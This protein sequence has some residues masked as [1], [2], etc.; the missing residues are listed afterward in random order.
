MKASPNP[1]INTTKSEFFK[2]QEYIDRCA[3]VFEKHLGKDRAAKFPNECQ[4]IIID[5]YWNS[6]GQVPSLNQTK[7][8]LKKI[9]NLSRDLYRAL[10]E[11]GGPAGDAL[12]DTW[13]TSFNSSKK[14]GFENTAYTEVEHILLHFRV[15]VS[16]AIDDA[17]DSRGWEKKLVPTRELIQGL[18]AIYERSTGKKATL[19]RMTPRVIKSKHHVIKDGVEYFHE[20]DFFSFVEEIYFALNIQKSNQATGEDIRKA[21]QDVS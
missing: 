14:P 6:R 11:I 19:E 13:S 16:R 20:G 15:V 21:L 8:E 5:Y 17:P 3:P 12:W 7:A 2:L 9:Y 4:G 1:R 10:S 18:A